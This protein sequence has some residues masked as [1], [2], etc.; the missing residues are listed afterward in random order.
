MCRTSGATT[1]PARHQPDQERRG[2][3]A[4][5]R[6]AS[7]RC[8]AGWRTRSGGRR[9]ASRRAT[10][11]YR[12]GGRAGE[13]RHPVRR[14]RG[15]ARHS[16][17]WP[18]GYGSRRAAGRRR[19]AAAPRRRP[20]APGR[21]C[22]P[23]Q[24]DDPRAVVQ[25]GGDVQRHVQPCRCTSSAD[26]TVALVLTTSRSPGCRHVGRSRAPVVQSRRRTTASRTWSRARPRASGGRSPR[27][28]AAARTAS[29]DGRAH[30]V[31]LG[32]VRQLRGP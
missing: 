27:C 23:A 25:R 1:T 28:R 2:D 29:G 3:T 6:S 16:R 26:G 21:G 13:V 12:I 22:R 9:S 20:A 5:R 17:V 30:A 18:A 32:H 24:L 15:T 31:P 8:R 11:R 14:R 7:R 19:A 10:Y 4:G